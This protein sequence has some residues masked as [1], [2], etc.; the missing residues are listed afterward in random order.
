MKKIKKSELYIYIF[1]VFSAMV[2]FEPK[3][4]TQ[5][6]VTT[7]LF[8]ALNVLVFCLL[9]Y[10][11]IKYNEKFN[12]TI[13]LFIVFRIYYLF[14]MFVNDVFSDIDK[15]GYLTIMSL[16]FF[17]IFE[18]AYKKKSIDSLIKSCVI[19]LTLYLIIN[20]ITLL[21]C[22]RGIIPSDNIF[23]TGEGD[24]YFLGNK[25]AYTTYALIAILFGFIKYNFDNK[26]YHLIIT[27]FFALFNIVYAQITTAMIICILFVLYYI[28]AK[29]YKFNIFLT[30]LIPIVIFIAV[31]FFNIQ[32]Y[33]SF[34]IVNVF[35]KSTD[36]T[37]RTIIWSHAISRIFDSN[38]LFL[39]GH[40]IVNDGM[41]VN[42]NG[43]NW[44]SHNQ[45]LQ[46]LFEV[47]L[48]GLLFFL[49]II[50]S[51]EKNKQKNKNYYLILSMLFAFLIGGITT[52]IFEI[53]NSYAII[54]S[55]LFY[56]GITCNRE[57]GKI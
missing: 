18:R 38:T 52:Q 12:I 11:K 55:L 37:S 45:Y 19:V 41:F 40:G 4:F 7:Y 32:E 34:I 42:V 53:A 33:F 46:L 23:D 39:F 48:F 26:K 21:F 17:L 57:T 3:I 16:N 6:S 14:I 51:C 50:I 30:I 22:K 8:A 44:Q 25:T 13:L 56:D 24:F 1:Y 5:F 36:L 29:K 54:A 2:M 9:I 49:F 31:V 47:G 10:Q 35:H 28:F 15:W 27:L 20:A 43:V